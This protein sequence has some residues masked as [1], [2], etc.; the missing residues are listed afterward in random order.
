MDHA[1]S[2]VSPDQRR[3][4]EQLAYRFLWNRADAEDA[5][6]DALI[7]A[8]QKRSELRDDTKWWSWVRRIVVRRSLLVRRQRSRR[9][10]D[11]QVGEWIEGERYP[12]DAIEKRE[13]FAALRK[14]IG[15]LPDKQRMAVTLRYLEQMSYG[16]MAEMMEIS[17][18]TVRV[19]V[20][21]G[22]ESLRS[23]MRAAEAVE[24]ESGSR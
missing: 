16:E 2:E 11:Q 12:D 5:T 22:L 15:E 24:M 4:L 23:A 14:T 1:R 21:H 13:R 3:R 7:A 10:G 9:P 20:C 6:Q 17:E 8:H 19:H 18:A